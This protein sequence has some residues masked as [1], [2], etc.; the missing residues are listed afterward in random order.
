VKIT[1]EQYLGFKKYYD[2]LK[3]INDSLE[4]QKKNIKPKIMKRDGE[5]MS[6]L[7][8]L[9]DWYDT[10]CVE[11]SRYERAVE[12]FEKNNKENTDELAAISNAQML[13]KKELQNTID[14]IYEYEEEYGVFSG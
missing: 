8:D 7:Q 2:C 3:D 13:I 14:W 6:S 12:K 5:I 11:L 10:G 1:K 9:R 4:K